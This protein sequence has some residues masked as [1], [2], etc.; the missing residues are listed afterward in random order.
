[1]TAKGRHRDQDMTDEKDEGEEA[2]REM[3]DAAFSLIERVG[4][5]IELARGIWEDAFTE[6]ERIDHNQQMEIGADLMDDWERAT[7]NQVKRYDQALEARSKFHIVK[8]EPDE[9]RDE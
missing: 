8:N 7:I 4:G 9:Q 3:I 2:W 1:M 5:N 6:A